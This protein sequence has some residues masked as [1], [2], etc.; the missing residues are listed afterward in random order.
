MQ[1]GQDIHVLDVNVKEYGQPVA[2]GW[3]LKLSPDYQLPN[4]N[5]T[6]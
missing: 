4:P 1:V 5:V 3:S 2:V 6:L